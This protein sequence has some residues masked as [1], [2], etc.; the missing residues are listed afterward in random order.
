MINRIVVLLISLCFLTTGY[1]SNPIKGKIKVLI[2]DGQN[3]HTVWPKSTIM[4]KQYLEETGLFTVDIARTKYL[5]NSEENKSW[6]GYANVP[7]GIEGKPKT[8]PDFSPKFSKYDVVIS[9]FGWRAASWPE[10]TKLAFEK[11]IEKGGGFVSVHAADNSFPEWAAYNEMIAIGGWGGRTEKDGPYLYVDKDNKVKRDYSPGKGGTHGKREA[12]PITIFDTEHPIT[13]G[14]PKV[15][16]HAPD[17]C[18]AFLRGPAKNVAI[19]ATA[20]STKKKPEL[21]QKEPVA[22]V[23]KYGKGRV[24]HTPLGHDTTSFECVGFITLLKRGVEWAATNKVTQTELPEDFPTAEK[25][26]LRPFVL[27]K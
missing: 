27:P 10:K 21:E 26:S 5:N 16:M 6:L 25:T 14:M 15:W 1:A 4:M 23:V 7:E 3:N 18:Y 17:E 2:V 22:L 9:N 8:D 19:L 20:V 24:F 13:K 11:Y 12:F